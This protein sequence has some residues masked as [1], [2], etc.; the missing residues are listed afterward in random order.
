[1][2]VS[3]IRA[4]LA[5]CAVC[6][7]L[8]LPTRSQSQSASSSDPTV[9]R[10]AHIDRGEQLA[11]GALAYRGGRYMR[12]GSSSAR[13]FDCSGLTQAVYRGW[14][15]SIP[16]TPAAQ[17]QC[18]THIA[19]SELVSGDLVFFQGTCRRGISHV[20]IYIGNGKF[21][22]AATPREGIIVSALSERYYAQ[23]YAGARRILKH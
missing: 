3:L 21:I 23:H 6:A 5:L 4:A 12:G 22:H 14:G 1:M 15:I 11:R 16:R 19:K 2:K 10:S 9:D 8:W 18:G 7:L 17:Y 13:G 20:G